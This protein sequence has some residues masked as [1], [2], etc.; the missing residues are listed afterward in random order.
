MLKHGEILSWLREE[1][2]VA[3]ERLWF[4]ADAVRQRSVG[5][6]IHLRG[7]VE[8]SNHCV[9]AC[10]YCGLRYANRELTRYRM[11]PDEIVRAADRASAWGCGTVV[12]QAGEDPHL[13]TEMISRIVMQIK[14]RTPLAVTLSL[15]ERLLDELRMWHALGADR[16]L[17]RFETSDRTLFELIHPPHRQPSDRLEMLRRIKAMGFEAGGGVMIGIPGQTYEIL[18]QDIETFRELDLDMIGGVGPFIPHPQTPLGQG[19]GPA[20]PTAQQV[21]PTDTMV[22]KVIAL[23]RLACPTANIPATTALATVNR[24]TGRELAWQRGANVVMPNFTPA[25]YRKLYEIYPDKACIGEGEEKCVG[26]LARRIQSV[27]REVGVGPG[28]RADQTCVEVRA[29]GSNHE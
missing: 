19:I 22:Y 1:D 8:I 6:A 11:T 12:L 14:A 28:S 5:P 18:A 16:Y 2:P 25:K 24:A 9:R 4:M 15:G 23:A 10:H 17:L 3:L 13:T 26:C 7:L 29:S 27:G 20:A 21:P